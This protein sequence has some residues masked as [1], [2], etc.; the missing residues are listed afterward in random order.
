MKKFIYTITALLAF[1]IS[2]NAQ[3][4]IET[5]DVSAKAI[6]D[7]PGDGVSTY[8]DGGILLPYVADPATAGSESGTL[9]YNA[10]DGAVYVQDNANSW[11]AITGVPS[12]VNNIASHDVAQFGE[13][14]AE[15][16]VINNTGIDAT[17]TGVLVLETADRALAL[18]K[19]NGVETLESPKAGMMVYDVKR[20]ALAIF[21]GEVWTLRN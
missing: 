4:G 17:A 10:T 21:N 1:A 16:A 6:L 12:D 15:G 2:A 18:P 8:A 9:I 5:E 20:K 7:F 11:V 13:N 14:S 3:V 19:I